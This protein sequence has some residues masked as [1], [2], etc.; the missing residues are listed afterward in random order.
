MAVRLTPRRLLSDWWA[1]S[2]L[3]LGTL[4]RGTIYIQAAGE[5]YLGILLHDSE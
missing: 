2:V 4:D 3:G 1:G 5:G